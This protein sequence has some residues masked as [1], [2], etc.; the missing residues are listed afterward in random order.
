MPVSVTMPRLGESVTEGTVTRWLKQEG[1]TVEVDEP[2][3]EVS[4]DKVD[5]EIP[6]PAAGVLTRIVVGEDET[7][8]VGSELAVISGEGES[9]G[10]GAAPQQQEEAPAEQAAEAAAEP[11]AEAEQS[12]VEEPTEQPAQAAPAPSGEGT[13][14]QMPALGESVTEGTVTRW[15]KQVGE[16][17][18]VDEPLLEVSTDKVDTEIPSPVAGTVLEIKVAEDETAEVGATLAVVGAA[19]GAPAESKPEPKPEAEAKPEPQAEPEP[20]AKPEP[21]VSEPTP[22]MSYNEPAAEA[23]TAQEPVKAEQAA[24]PPAPAAPQRAAAPANGGEQAAGYVTPLVRKLASQHNVD[25]ASVNGTGVGGRIRK[26]D[27]LDAAEQAKAA[28]AAPAPA[29]Q[30]TAGAPA[31]PAAKPQPS[32]K[33]G[34]TEKLPRIRAAIAKRMLSSLHEMAQLTTVVEVD[35]TKI[36]KLRA[37]AKESFQ[38]RHG[39]KL[40]FLPFFALAAI[41]ALQAYP[42]VNASMD[43]DGGTITYPDAENLGIAVD[44]ERGLLVPVIHNAGDLNLGGIAK[45]VA[46]LAERTRTNKISPDEIAGATFTLTNTGSRGALFDTPIVPSPQSAMLGT[47][48]VVKRP[49]VVNDPELGEVIAVRQMVYLA[50][51]YDHRLIDGAD[52][53][54]FLTAVKERLEAGNFEAE[55]GL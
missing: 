54:R 10:G 27:V 9:A 51:S 13:P 41:E 4:T 53:A 38:Q 49:V 17:V 14:V 44:T 16:T 40:S 15:L 19:G 34:T 33:R 35:V 24:Q 52:A 31:K 11:Q 22:G 23:E 48:A 25:L 5:T 39:V 36:A 8:E 28:K 46:D 12:A 45:R 1:D 21:Q 26:Q 30:P 29:A 3:L 32:A 42:I 43:L 7:A 37:Q 20:E 50:L 6:S 55:L 2:L 18:E 47:G